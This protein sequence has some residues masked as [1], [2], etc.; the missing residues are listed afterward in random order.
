MSKN[1]RLDSVA[2]GAAEDLF[3]TIMHLGASEYHALSLYQKAMG[4]LSEGLVDVEDDKVLDETL[5]KSE[6][7]KQDLLELADIRRNAMLILFEMYDGD[8]DVWCQ[9]K[10]LSIAYVTAVEA[11]QSSDDLLLLDLALSINKKLTEALSRFLGTEIFDCASCLGDYL[12][13][14]N[15]DDSSKAEHG[16]ETPRGGTS[17]IR[18]SNAR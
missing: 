4:E 11:F 14:A 15:K 12:K 1:E 7:H 2:D 18:N 5:R 9:V 13:G 3:R 10:H 6:Q 17:G 8:K 16:I